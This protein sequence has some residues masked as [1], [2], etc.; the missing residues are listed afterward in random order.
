[1]RIPRLAGLLVLAALVFWLG[2]GSSELSAQPLLQDGVFVRDSG[3]TIWLVTGGQR[4]QVP[5]LPATDEAIF[6]VPDS[7]AWVIQGEGG[8]LALGPQP[9]YVSA[10]P[11]VLQPVVAQATATPTMT[12]DPPPTVRIQVD[13]DRIQAGQSAKITVIADDNTGLDWIEWEGTTE[14]SDNGNDNRQTGDEALDGNH[15]FD[16]DGRTPCAN[17]WDVS[18]KTGG[19]FVLRAR[20]RDTEGN[21]S[22]WVTLDFRVQ[23]SAATA[24]PTRTP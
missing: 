2:R 12:E 7:G 23:G 4:A 21:R 5:F 20:A 10:P 18:P 6:S 8:S 22:E 1:M 3:G 16:C 14:E 13:D 24:T 9:G 11:I 15:R 17:V 19:R